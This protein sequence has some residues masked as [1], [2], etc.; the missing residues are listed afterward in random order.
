VGNREPNTFWVVVSRLPHM[1]YNMG[2]RTRTNQRPLVI[3]VAGGVLAVAFTFASSDPIS[4]GTTTTPSK[5]VPPF[6]GLTLAHARSLARTRGGRVY[7]AL[8]IPSSQPTE[9]VLSQSP[10]P[11]W[12]V[13]LVVSDGPLRNDHEVLPGESAPPVRRECAET[14]W[15]TADGNVYPL[16]CSGRRVNVG[17]WL[18]YAHDHPSMM[19]LMRATSFARVTASLCHYTVGQ[20]KGFNVFEETLPEQ[21]NVF[22]LAAAYNGWRVPRGLS[23][24][25]RAAASR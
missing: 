18:F 23:C 16:V 19:S 1:G 2:V 8:E 15:L 6:K 11:T 12:P 24:E 4:S 10:N 13:G 22:T 17:A 7:V 20:P 14:V 5:V 21:E 3:L 9:I 25:H